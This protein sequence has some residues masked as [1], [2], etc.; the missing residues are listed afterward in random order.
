MIGLGRTLVWADGRRGMLVA[1]RLRDAMCLVL[2]LGAR[3]VTGAALYTTSDS[4]DRK[5][6]ILAQH[7]KLFVITDFDLTLTT[8]DS[9][10]C[11]DILGKSDRMPADVRRKFEPLLDFS[12]PFEPPLDGGGWWDRANEILVESGGELRGHNRL[13]RTCGCIHVLRTNGLRRMPVGS[14]AEGRAAASR[15]GGASQAASRCQA[16]AAAA[17]EA[18]RTRARSQRWVHRADRAI[19]RGTGRAACEHARELKL[20]RVGRGVGGLVSSASRAAR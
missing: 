19:P 5:R 11:H 9:Q 13:E 16:D 6:H 2:G 20:A 7:E 8:G 17:R 14:A 3:A 4:F 15:D 10:E 12:T 1:S 18:W